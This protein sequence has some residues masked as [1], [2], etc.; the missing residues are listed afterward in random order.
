MGNRYGGAHHR[1]HRDLG[2]WVGDMIL[3]V[4]ASVL[5]YLFVAHVD[6][7]QLELEPE[8]MAAVCLE[9]NVPE[10]HLGALSQ[11]SMWPAYGEG[12]LFP[13]G[14]TCTFAMADGSE[15]VTRHTSWALFVFGL[16]P[17]TITGVAGIRTL[18][19]RRKPH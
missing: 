16:V 7:G 1:G 8:S 6:H 14:R 11:E 9:E 12:R 10:E 13:L 2:R 15:V 18:P 4:S 19:H 17:L 5:F 3:A